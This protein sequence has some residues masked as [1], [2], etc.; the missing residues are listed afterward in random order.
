MRT[1]IIVEHKLVLFT[2]FD[3]SKVNVIRGFV[4][5]ANSRYRFSVEGKKGLAMAI[6][7]ILRRHFQKD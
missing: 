5:V 3:G 7:N 1:P 4:R 6:S 2:D